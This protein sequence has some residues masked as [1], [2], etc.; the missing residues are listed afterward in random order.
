ML[1]SV[2]LKSAGCGLGRVERAFFWVSA[3]GIDLSFCACF[4][5]LLVAD[6]VWLAG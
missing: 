3:A 4:W 2:S 6:F 5:G 1:L